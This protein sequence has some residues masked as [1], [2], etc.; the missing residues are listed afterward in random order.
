MYCALDYAIDGINHFDGEYSGLKR[1]S[2]DD[3]ED[4]CSDLD[5]DREYSCVEYGMIKDGVVLGLGNVDDLKKM[6]TSMLH[7]FIE[8]KYDQTYGSKYQQSSRNERLAE[9]Y[10]VLSDIKKA[11][12]A[13]KKEVKDNGESQS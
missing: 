8:Y 9:Y 6:T 12:E 10:F 1:K 4:S 7:F 2:D 13:K 5:F 3:D 11:H